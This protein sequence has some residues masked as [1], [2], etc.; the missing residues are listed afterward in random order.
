V[1]RRE[2]PHARVSDSELALTAVTQPF[3]LRL[4]LLPCKAEVTS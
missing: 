1:S 4:N 2:E 3:K